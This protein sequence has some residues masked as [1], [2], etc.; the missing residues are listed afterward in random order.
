MQSIKFQYNYDVIKF[1]DKLIVYV[2]C[3]R[4]NSIDS[5]KLAIIIYWIPTTLKIEAEEVINYFLINPSSIRIIRICAKKN[6]LFK[7][8]HNDWTSVIPPHHNLI[9]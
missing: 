4:I 5:I 9:S 8:C 7:N 3:I 6:Y 2:K 1:K